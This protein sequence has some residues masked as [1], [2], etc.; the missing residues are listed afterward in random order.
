MNKQLI[1][2]IAIAILLICV[3]LSGCNGQKETVSN[4]ITTSHMIQYKVSTDITESVLIY[5]TDY[6]GSLKDI[7]ITP[8]S[9][10]YSLPYTSFP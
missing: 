6:D 4:D 2:I 3:G 10:I 9:L 1:I 5:Y 8:D 7:T